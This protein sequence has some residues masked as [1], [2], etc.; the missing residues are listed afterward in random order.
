VRTLL[1]GRRDPYPS[2]GLSLALE[3]DT[4]LVGS[5]HGATTFERRGPGLPWREA[6]VLTP[7]AGPPGPGSNVL[8]A[9]N[10]AWVTKPAQTT[11]EP[12]AFWEFARAN[13][14]APWAEVARVALPDGSVSSWRANALARELLN[15]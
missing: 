2:F 5:R 9:G 11:L 1:P 15:P 12:C 3:D 13:A 10:R 14:G 4:L 7:S 8:L 6:Q